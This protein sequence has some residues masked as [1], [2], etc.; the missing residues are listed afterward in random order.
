MVQQQTNHTDKLSLEITCKKKGITFTRGEYLGHGRFS[1]WYEFVDLN[2]KE[3]YAGKIISKSRYDSNDF[4]KKISRE[5]EIL[6][7][8]NHD[9][10]VSLI[11]SFEDY[12]N[13][14]MIFQFCS[15]NT[16]RQFLRY[17]GILTIE[18]IRYFTKQICDGCSYL[19]ERNIVH[20]NIWL[21]S[22]FLDENMV[23][24]IGSFGLSKMYIKC[25]NEENI[26]CK[27]IIYTSMNIIN[28]DSSF[29]KDIWLIGC[30]LYALV[31]GKYPF[32]IKRRTN[33]IVQMS[34]CKLELPSSDSEDLKEVI[35]SLLHP[36]SIERPNANE[37]LN[38]KFFTDD[39]IFHTYTILQ[40]QESS[41]FSSMIFGN[42]IKKKYLEND[43]ILKESK[44]INKKEMKKE[45]NPLSRPSH[46]VSM[47]VD[48]SEK[49]NLL[50]KLS[51]NSTGVFFNDNTS[52]VLDSSE[53][54]LH[55]YD[56]DGS[57]E[58][59]TKTKSLSELQKKVNLLMYGLNY[60]N[61]SLEKAKINNSI[62]ENYDLEKIPILKGWFRTTKMIVFYLGNNILQI[63][64]FG[65]HTKIILS[66]L[67][68]S[69]SIIDGKKEME[70]YEL[71]KLKEVGCE[72]INVKLTGKVESTDINGF[73]ILY[74]S[75]NQNICYY[76]K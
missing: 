44:L 9:N 26:L 46:F 50:Y 7:S 19:H 2:K 16:L 35:T 47:W 23:L 51:D 45:R 43:K 38:F 40:C 34:F 33:I 49:H 30:V 10:I 65:C 1:T 18:E 69:L 20:R 63:N 58:I 75:I 3:F 5:I 64:F 61:G 24:K 4:H 21:D 17:R 27:P 15:N 25:Q 37:I 57:E 8:L 54:N 62:D 76:K 53:N 73:H 11:S 56:V 72:V 13:Y 12:R 42:E 36:S 32:E 68:M 59:F 52:I 31:Y 48:N 71:Q 55:Y 67:E 74:G 6:K 14:Y 41:T 22:L 28:N 29:K 66:L 39:P 70:S 60:M